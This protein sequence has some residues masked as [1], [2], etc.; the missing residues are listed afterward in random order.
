M[1]AEDLRNLDF[2]LSS[3][4]FYFP[5]EVIGNFQSDKELFKQNVFLDIKQ[6]SVNE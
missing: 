4:L 6:L 5:W 2:H 1:L 3:S